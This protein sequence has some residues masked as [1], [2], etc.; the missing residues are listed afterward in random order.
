VNAPREAFIAPRDVAARMPIGGT[1]DT[2]MRELLPWASSFAVV[3]VS[4]FAVGAVAFG[5]SGALYAGANLE[6]AGAPLSASVHAEQAV[7]ANAWLRGEREIQALAVTAT[8]CGHCRQFLNELAGADRLAIF[9]AGRGP[10][11]LAEL[12][13]ASF[14][15]RD[16]GVRAGLLEA[17]DHPLAARVDPDDV[18][19]RA[20][21]AAAEAAYAP[22][23][24][25]YAGVA[26]TDAAGSVVTGRYAECAAYNPSLPALQSAL[27]ALA[28]RRI[29]ASSVVG[30]VMVEA[31]GATSQRAAAEALL[32]AVAGVRLRYLPATSPP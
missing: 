5:A 2:V 15:P 16:L 24:R 19:A 14:G 23:T 12:L 20:A 21:L 25:A 10:S 3:P 26:L 17:A 11:T 18:L 27:S 29:A 22:Y 8:P 9:S 6:F 1:I 7:V 31:G 32:E 4:G 28:L 30:A 13:P